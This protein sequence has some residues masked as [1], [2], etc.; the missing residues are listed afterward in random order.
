MAEKIIWEEH[1]Q[2][3][4]PSDELIQKFR[5]LSKALDWEKAGVIY[6]NQTIWEKIVSL[7]P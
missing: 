6:K 7:L 1:G 2:I 4:V 5:I 3:V